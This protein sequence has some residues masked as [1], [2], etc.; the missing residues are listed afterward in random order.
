MRADILGTEFRFVR[1]WSPLSM[2]VRFDVCKSDV[3]CTV[4]W[5]QEVYTTRVE[6]KDLE[7]YT[8]YLLQVAVSNYYTEYLSEAMSDPVK[9]TTKPGG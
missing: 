9:F 1:L 5:R 2:Y 3:C 8:E 4:L 6:L 7:P